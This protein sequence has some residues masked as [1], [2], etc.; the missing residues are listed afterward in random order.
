MIR[1]SGGVSDRLRRVA[2]LELFG[3]RD[4]AR[5]LLLER[6]DRAEAELVAHPADELDGDR[7][8]VK[9]AGEAD[10][11]GLD[12]AAGAVEGRIRADANGGCVAHAV[13]R[14][15]ARVNTLGRDELIGAFEIRGGHA[16]RATARVAGD[17]LAFERVGAAE[18]DGRV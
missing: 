8:A 2:R 15:P 16:D 3:G 9:V 14:A 5:D 17:D 1:R 13:D 4:V 18:A 11:V 10:Q 12:L 6:V 7:A